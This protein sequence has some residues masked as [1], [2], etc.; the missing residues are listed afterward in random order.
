MY[1]A[2]SIRELVTA[3][4]NF[5]DNTAMT[6]LTGHGAFHARVASNV[7]AMILRE[8]DLRPAAEASETRRLEA[9]LGTIARE[10]I[11]MNRLLCAA[12]REGQM[13]ISTPGLLEHLKTTTI[14]QLMIDQP[15]YSGL[16]DPAG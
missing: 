5:V 16:R 10:G 14:D 6:G 13:D 2:P 8:L 4:K 7:L 15:N 9:L 12:I 11:D 1:D 3:V